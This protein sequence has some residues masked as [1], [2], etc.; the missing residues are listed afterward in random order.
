[1]EKHGFK[2][3]WIDGALSEEEK[4]DKILRLYNS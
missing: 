2:I 3:H 1:M 4:V